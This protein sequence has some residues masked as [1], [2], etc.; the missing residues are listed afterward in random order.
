M[1]PLSFWPLH[2]THGSRKDMVSVFRDID[3]TLTTE[4]AITPD[5]FQALQNL[6]D[7]GRMLIPI[8]GRPVGWSIP[9]AST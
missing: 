5:A 2:G 4:G 6:K 3:D 8:T 9:F 7:A 1:A